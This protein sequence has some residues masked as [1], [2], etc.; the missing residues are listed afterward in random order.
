M[1]NDSDQTAFIAV[2]IVRSGINR[3]LRFNFECLLGD[4][5]QTDGDTRGCRH[6]WEKLFI[7]FYEMVSGQREQCS[8]FVDLFQRISHWTNHFG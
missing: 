4:D 7:E 6:L 1:L 2:Q 5:V 8:G 3:S